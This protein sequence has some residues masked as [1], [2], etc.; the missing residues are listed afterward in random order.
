M[1][2]SVKVDVQMD[3]P[4]HYWLLKKYKKTVTGIVEKVHK[5]LKKK[6]VG[7]LKTET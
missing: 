1:K 5:I 4:L 7:Q 3:Q 2:I 6:N